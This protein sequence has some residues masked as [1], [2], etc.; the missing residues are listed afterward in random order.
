[1]HRLLALGLLVLFP[2]AACSDSGGASPFVQDGGERGDAGADRG[3]TDSRATDGPIFGQPCLDD[4]QCDDRVDCTVDSC[5]HDLGRCQYVL[6]DSRCQNGV[7]CDGI[8]RCD[9]DLGCRQGSILDCNDDMTCTIDRCVEATRMCAHDPRDADGDGSPD[10]HCQANG[11]CDDNDPTVNPKHVEVCGNGKDDN[12]D[13]KIDETPCQKP[14]HDTCLDP[15]IVTKSGIYELDTTASS[16][17]YPGTCAP[18]NAATRKDVVV[19]L[20]LTGGPFDADIVAEAP[21]GTVA[22]GL[23]KD[24]GIL[25]SEIGCGAGVMGKAGNQI[26]RVRARSLAMGT[27]PVYVWVDRDEKVLLH[28]TLGPPTT[29]PANETCGTAAPIAL[30]TPV[31]ASLVGTKKDLASRCGYDAG[32]L[33]YQFDLPDAAD[34]T[35][36]AA[37]IDGYG[38]PVVSIRKEACAAP[39]DEIVCGYGSPARSFARALPKGKYFVAVS[40]SGPTDVQLEVDATSPPATPPADETC[41]SAPALAA[42]RTLGISLTGHTDDIDL[43]CAPIASV[44]AAYALDLATPSDVLLV[45]RIAQGDTGAVSLALPTCAGPESSKLCG[46]GASSPVRASLRG[47]PAG[48]YR[49]VVESKLGN[50][51]ELTA[52]VRPAVP[53]TLVPFADTCSSATAIPETGGFFQG[54]TSNASADYSAGCDVTG[55]PPGGAPDQI[56]KFT[57][58]QKKRVVFDMQGSGYSTLLDVRKGETCPGLEMPGACSAGYLPLRS[59]LDL[60]LDPGTYWVQVDGYGSDQG[61]W[62]LD[63]RVVDP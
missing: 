30:S 40:A 57:L 45:L 14:T 35:A 55:V 53:P 46:K 11:D 39:E 12:C 10:G 17:D 2:A 7:Y 49:A 23:G 42:N 28:V 37:S 13:G 1:M 8:E 21:G 54:N 44:D 63:V 6:D 26:A 29:A 15:L 52:F 50:P 43:G 62:F 59:Y 27:Y 9:P 51:V 25:A 32:D 34:V 47:A 16:F 36:Y 60:T 61:T 48:P 41:A 24:C 22:V 31:V 5:N 4:G 56:M 3:A 38:E 33:V 58:S 20:Q 19:A 18:M